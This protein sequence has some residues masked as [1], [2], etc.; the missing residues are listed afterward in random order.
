MII[1][2]E[3]RNDVQLAQLSYKLLA[4]VSV[5]AG[6]ALAA[7]QLHAQNIIEEVVVTAQKRA[8]N[9]NEV[10]ISITA[11]N[12]E[13]LRQAG[14]R[15]SKDIL[16]VAPGVLLDSTASGGL[17]SN[18]TIRGVSQ[19]DY[20]SN[21]ESPNSIYIDDVYLA[22]SS[23]A[24][25]P[26]Y[27]LER[28]EILRGPQ[29]T[30]FGRASSGGLAHFI[31]RGPTDT[32]EGFGEIGYGRFNSIHAEGAISGPLSDTVR[33]RL[34]GRFEDAD[35]WWKNAN[36]NGQDTF[37]TKFFGLRGQL[38]V[39][40]SEQLVANLIVSY[41][42]KPRH[43]EGTYEQEPFYIDDSGFPAPLPN[44]LDAYG[45]GP[46]NDFTGYRDSFDDAHTGNFNNVG[47]F[48]NERFSPTLKLEWTGDDIT[49]TSISN[50]TYFT[51]DYNDDC[52]AGPLDYCQYPFAQKLDQFSQELRAHGETGGLLWTAGLYYLNIDQTVDMFFEFPALSGTDFSFSDT[53]GLSQKTSSYAI[54]GQ[55]EYQLSSVLKTTFGLRYT[56]DKKE[57]DSKVYFFELGNGYF[58]GV[59]TT[60][61]DP[62]FLAYDFSEETVGDLATSTDNLW[63]G[64]LQLDYTPTDD[65][66]YYVGVSRGKKAAGFNTNVSGNLTNSDTPF[67]SETVWSYEAGTKL[68][69]MDSRMQFNASGFYYDYKDF[70]GFAY[71]GLQGVVGNYD[72]EFYGGELEI[73][74]VPMDDLNLILGVSYLKSKLKDI[75]TAYAG[76]VD[77]ESVLTPEWTINGLMS[78]SFE[79]G[80][81]QATLQ[82]SFDYIDDRFTS[83][84]NNLATF[85]KG[86]FVHNARI[87]YRLED[88]GIEISAFVDNISDIDRDV[89]AFDLISSGGFIIRSL[90]KPRTW[91]LTIRKEFF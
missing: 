38:E 82:W 10:G 17:S 16:R 80:P 83:V 44:D 14:V 31:S 24:S 19:S 90:A 35:G 81:G 9:V 15:D 45:T 85:I 33:G 6:I 88:E 37:E 26:I 65:A 53:N 72:G 18:L 86:T 89:F 43:R 62:P 57:Y 77:Q 64:K 67:G 74:A 91:G 47:F 54:F 20:S 56:R 5:C 36:P 78:K 7:N 27:D 52:D 21:Q 48:T 29:G 61:F 40:M 12:G 70:Q 87:S 60:V 58:G 46:G 34:S 1:C 68:S 23:A 79:I 3:W 71:N 73:H 30:L 2:N 8:Q 13:Q 63:T 49:V 32:M 55:A 41:D 69:L 25:F 76:V 11:F 28:V 75:P 39:D 22:S 59:G 51:F 4:S 50:Y 84:D 66:L 42:K